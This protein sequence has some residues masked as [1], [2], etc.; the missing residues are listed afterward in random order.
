MLLSYFYTVEATVQFYKSWSKPERIRRRNPY[1]SGFREQ[2]Q[3]Q[4][5]ILRVLGQ[6]IWREGRLLNME[7]L[8]C[9]GVDVSSILEHCYVKL[10]CHLRTLQKVAA[11]LKY[12][13]SLFDCLLSCS[14][15]WQEFLTPLTSLST[16]F[17]ALINQIRCY[18]KHHECNIF[19]TDM[20]W[21]LPAHP[22]L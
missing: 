2:W 5:N 10:E 11:R 9:S 4:S 13:H 22:H 1:S 16:G 3:R 12:Y 15:T 7:R 18:M 8:H 19:R 20:L 6:W 14:G 17:H 21:K